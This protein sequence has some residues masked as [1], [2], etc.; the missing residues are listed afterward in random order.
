MIRYAATLLT[1]TSLIV[2]V[3]CAGNGKGDLSL[4]GYST[5]PPYDPNIRSV[6][7]PVFKNPIFATTPFRGNEVQLTEEI[8]QELNRRK[9][10]IRVVSDPSRADTELI[11]TISSISKAPITNS[12]SNFPREYEVVIGC[13]VVWRDNRT[14]KNLTN[15]RNPTFP[16]VEPAFDPSLPAPP[17]PAPELYSNAVTVT[18]FG[19]VVP[20]L[21]ES[22]AT[23][24]QIANKVIARKIVDMMEAP[25]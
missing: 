25:W 21:G 18:G 17:P 19:R 20:E 24:L 2:L 7:I 1:L 6:Y 23:G 5:A 10:P 22:T 15:S 12:L 11:G 9:T 8:V 3:G 16:V 13:Q 14:A 4:F